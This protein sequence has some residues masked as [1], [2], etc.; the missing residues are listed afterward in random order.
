MKISFIVIDLDIG[1]NG[2]VI[3]IMRDDYDS[4]FKM[5]FIDLVSI[6]NESCFLWNVCN[7]NYIMNMGI[8]LYL[9]II[10]GY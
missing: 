8:F 4:L 1:N 3:Y 6:K 10:N 2:N 5:N 9:L 7:C